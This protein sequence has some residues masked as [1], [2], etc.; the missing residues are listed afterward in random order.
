[1]GAKFFADGPALPR[2]DEF[3]PVFHGW[4]QKQ[5]LPGHLLIDVHNYSHI[6]QGP[7]ILLVAHEGNFSI[8]MSGGRPGLMYYRKSPTTLAPADHLAVILRSAVEACRL[9]ETGGHMRFNMDE[10]MMIANDRLNA[11][12]DDQ[13]LEALEAPL[14]N[15]LGSTFE[16]S[17]FELTRT[18]ID[19]K[20][21]FA[22]TCRRLG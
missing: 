18:S 13:T 7:G 6:H 4:I 1:M 15:A 10:F 3:I 20:E 5:A 2:L 22:I 12:N 8:D 17:E 9:L 21:R 19:P 16:S 11:P 14:R